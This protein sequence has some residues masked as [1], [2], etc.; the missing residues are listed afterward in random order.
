M[1]FKTSVEKTRINNTHDFGLILNIMHEVNDTA[2][3]KGTAKPFIEAFLKK[4]YSDNTDR[5]WRFDVDTR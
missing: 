3:L 2:E 4:H 5:K 1:I